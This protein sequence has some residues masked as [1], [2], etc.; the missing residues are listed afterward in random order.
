M[1][2]GETALSFLGLGLRPPAVSWGVL[3]QASQKVSVL[4]VAPWLVSPVAFVIVTVLAFN[5]VGDGLRDA[6]D[7][8]S[9]F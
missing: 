8:H 3:L 9:R 5:F 2:L 1:I 7:P 6:V 4:G